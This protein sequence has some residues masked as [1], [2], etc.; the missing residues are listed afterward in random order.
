M[1]LAHNNVSIHRTQIIKAKI[2]HRRLLPRLHSFVYPYLSI[3]VPVRSP[4]QNWLVSVDPRS[5]WEC[6]F[7][8]ISA[9]DHLHRVGSSE[10]LSDHLDFYLEQQGIK[11]KD[12]PH[13]YLITSP[14][15]MGYKSSPASFWYLY[16]K[17]LELKNV[18]AEVNN[19]F[20][21]RRVYVFS[22]GGASTLFQQTHGKDFHVSP[23]NSRKGSYSISTSDPAKTKDFS[24]TVTLCTSQGQPKLVARWWSTETAIDPSRYPVAKAVWFLLTWAWVVFLTY[25]RILIQAFVLSHVRKLHIWYRPEPKITAIPRNATS[26][27]KLLASI[28]SQYLQ[29]LFQQL[30]KPCNIAQSYPELVRVRLHIGDEG[31]SQHENPHAMEGCIELKV[32]TPQFFRQ[33]MTYRNLSGFLA[34]TLLDPHDENHTASSNDPLKLIRLLREAELV[35]SRS[36]N[37]PLPCQFHFIQRA[38]WYFYKRLRRT[39]PAKGAYPDPGCPKSRSGG[40]NELSSILLSPAPDAWNFLDHFVRK[41]FPLKLQIQFMLAVLVLQLRAKIMARIGG[42]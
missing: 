20:D 42:Q 14:S 11:P 37:D 22:N 21:E 34:N 4:A 6:R 41:R 7:F 38:L 12:F 32:H 35:E 39:T 18:I 16:T 26:S 9:H 27:E 24:V 19:T 28:W 29:L 23:F 8:N 1:K 31:A 5:W 3:G 40:S 2:S 30:H 13:V 25:P 36:T 33:M 10:C 17:D 15:I